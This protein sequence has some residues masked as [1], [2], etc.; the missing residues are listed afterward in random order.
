MGEKMKRMFL[1]GVALA[2][3][4]PAVAQQGN[5][6][7]VGAVETGP[8]LRTGTDVLLKT[9]TELTTE[10]KALKVGDRFNLEVMEPVMLNG[11]AVIPVGAR[12]V[13]EITTVRNK[14]M[15][16]KSGNFDARLLYV[17]ANDRQIRLAGTLGDKGRKSGVGA[18][19]AS[20]IVFA[21]A[22]FFMT[23]TSA[24]LPAGTQIVGHLDEDVKIAFAP[25]AP[26]QTAAAP[27]P[28][29]PAIIPASVTRE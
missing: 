4:V 21:P 14:G 5:V 16:G 2:A 17:V 20:A 7:T 23:G 10:G 29:Q 8:M 6:M 19:A 13:G 1:C 22:G 15:W 3:A 25:A 26:P 27:A 9:T 12:A 11:V 24:R 28:L 18:V